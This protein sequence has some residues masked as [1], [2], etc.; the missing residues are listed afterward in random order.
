MGKNAF[1]KLLTGNLQKKRKWKINIK[2]HQ[3]Y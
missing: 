2:N 1:K 3:P